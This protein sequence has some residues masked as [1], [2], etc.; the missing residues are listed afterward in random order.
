MADDD[1]GR[2]I[3][4]HLKAETKEIDARLE[5]YA[6]GELDDD[7]R[8]ALESSGRDD[9]HLAE[10][11]ALHAPLSDELRSR[12]AWQAMQS[13]RTSKRRRRFA[14]ATGAA[15]VLAA[16]AAFFL[17]FRGD[18]APPLPEFAAVVEIGDLEWRG[19]PQGIPQSVAVDA[20]VT[21]LLRPARSVSGDIEAALWV[22]SVGGVFRSPAAAEKSPDGAVRWV[23][24][25]DALAR[26]QTGVMTFI[27][28]VGRAGT[29]PDEEQIGAAS[30]GEGWRAFS[31]TVDTRSPR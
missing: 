19:E 7:E 11:L 3:G 12:L 17:L 8:A 23:G 30:A 31:V 26:G 6:R 10:A 24:T 15:A 27:A 22:R 13:V 28:I 16:A 20:P 1:L 4:E 5:R 14:I 2:R 9:P 21:I 25:V 29:L 18:L